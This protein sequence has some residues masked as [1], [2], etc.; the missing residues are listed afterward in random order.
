MQE[1]QDILQEDNSEELYER[2]AF[3]VDKGQEPMRIDKWVQTRMENATRN[4]IQKGIE[5]GF[6]TVNGKPV[7][8]N[9]KIKPG[10]DILLL[11]FQHPD[12][13]EIKP[14]NIPLTI[15]YEDEVVIC[16]L[17]TSPSPRD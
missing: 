12:Q 8:C 1:D 10:D 2:K 11:S 7:K 14:E 13:S 6:L 9:Y 4:K 15:V 17:Y 16:L 3:H 5:A